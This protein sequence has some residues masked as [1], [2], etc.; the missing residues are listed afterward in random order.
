MA[1]IEVVEDGSDGEDLLLGDAQQ[2]V[3]VGTA[4]DDR[5]GGAV[6]VGRFIDDH[7]R[8]AGPGDDGPLAPAA[9][10]PGPRPARRSRKSD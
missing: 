6:E 10:P 7:G 8:I 2:V 3:V 9:W 1:A 5:A 4:L